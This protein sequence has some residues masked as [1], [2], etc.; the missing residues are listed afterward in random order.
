MRNSAGV[1]WL[2]GDHLGSA[3]LITTNAGATSGQLRY[4]P[5]GQRRVASGNIWTEYTFTDQRQELS[6]GLMDYDAR[7]Y[8]PLLARFISPDSIVPD[9]ANVQDWNR[10]AYVRHNPMKYVDPS[11]H[12]AFIPLLILGA[13]LAVAG[14]ATSAAVDA[15]IQTA[16]NY[17][18]TGNVL[19]DI[20]SAISQID[21]A[22]LGAS[23]VGGAVTGPV[24]GAGG[25]A[26]RSVGFKGVEKVLGYT[27]YSSLAGATG[28]AASEVA[29]GTFSGKGVDSGRVIQSTVMGGAAGPLSAATSSVIQ[30][31][32]GKFIS[33]AKSSSAQTTTT[34]LFTMQ[35][36]SVFATSQSLLVQ[37]VSVSVGIRA[38][39]NTPAQRAVFNAA[40]TASN[41]MGDFIGEAAGRLATTK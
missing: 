28:S 19:N 36:T 41:I 32:A 1:F 26:I 38:T 21:L 13:K 18:N 4:D 2:H 3:S 9:A 30:K 5:Y 16:S 15:T 24:L 29:L 14:A 37:T 8:S 20:G 39:S 10:Y 7:L 33:A 27:A 25:A 31:G 40:Q 6:V 35:Q 34:P 17:Q 23:A 22:Q 11:G 12:I